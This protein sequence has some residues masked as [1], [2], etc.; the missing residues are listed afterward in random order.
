MSTTEFVNDTPQVSKVAP[1]EPKSLLSLYNK[2]TEE[3]RIPSNGLVYPK[4]SGIMNSKVVNIRYMTAA[5][6]DDLT[7]PTLL[8]NGTWL[9]K[10]LS[11]CIATKT[12]DPEDL[13]VGDRNAL[14]FWLRQ[15]AYGADYKLTVKCPNCT[16]D[17]PGFTNNFMLD[18]LALKT[19]DV[20]PITEGTNAFEF[21]LPSTKAKVTF[22]LLTSRMANELNKEEEIKSNKGMA[23]DKRITSSLKKQ[24][25]EIDGVTD[26]KEI[27]DFIDKG[28]IAK[29]SVALRNYIQEITPDIILKQSATC[30]Y[31][32]NINE[33]DISIEAQF[34]LPTTTA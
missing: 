20:K 30:P 12:I 18:K 2:A 5:D 17:K 19:L 26:K 23:Q 29:D 13:L 27:A 4:V 1:E 3:V 34:F 22:S 6:E 11:N 16:C 7:S 8:R 33:F 15:T 21:I 25:M 10:I 24:I 14:L 31:T 9:T 32:G 28:M